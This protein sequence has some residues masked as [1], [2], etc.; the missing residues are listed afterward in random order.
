[1]NN[2]KGTN[3]LLR[4]LE[5]SDLQIIYRLENDVSAWHVSGILVPF[6]EFTVENYIG[7]QDDI[8]SS[9]QL[10]LIIEKD[11]KAIGHIDLFEFEP[12]NKRAG[13]GILIDEKER[14][15]GYASEALGLIIKYAFKLLRLRQLYCNII[16]DNEKSINLFKKHG[17]V[18]NGTRKDWVLIGDG[19]KDVY[20]L[21]LI[22]D[23][24]DI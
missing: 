1:M 9:K 13:V 18:I 3:I 5:P 24:K 16:V 15:N 2:L 6:S 4:A 7:T 10:K 21:Q 19:W 11:K 17:F 8:F 14:N 12:S 20:F 23:E 22:N